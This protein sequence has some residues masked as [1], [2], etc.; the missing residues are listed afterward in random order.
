VGWEEHGTARRWLVFGL[1]Q[2]HHVL[3]DLREAAK[4]LP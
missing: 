3:Y 1:G 2:K 4:D